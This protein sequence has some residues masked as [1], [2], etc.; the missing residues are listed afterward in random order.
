MFFVRVVRP[1]AAG[2]GTGIQAVEDLANTIAD[3]PAVGGDRHR[4]DQGVGQRG[5]RL[6]KLVAGHQVRLPS[7]DR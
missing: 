6:T 2:I 4:I 3:S 5:N 1:L 7:G